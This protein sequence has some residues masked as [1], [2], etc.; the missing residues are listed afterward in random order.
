MS[1]VEKLGTF[2]DKLFDNTYP[3]HGSDGK[4]ANWLSKPF[5]KDYQ[6]HQ[7]STTLYGGPLGGFI[8]DYGYQ[9]DKTGS[10][11]SALKYTGSQM[12][13]SAGVLAT[14]FAGI[15]GAGAYGAGGASGGSAGSSGAAGGSS[16]L[17][18]NGSLFGNEGMLGGQSIGS[19]GWES[20][21]PAS[22]FG[23]G[24]FLSTGNLGLGGVG[25]GMSG[26]GGIT[27]YLKKFMQN[28][29]G[30]QNQQ[31]V[32]QTQP[33]WSMFYAYKD[34]NPDEAQNK[35]VGPALRFY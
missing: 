14:I 18:S 19:L 5:G 27:D 32:Q 24:S 31:Q 11:D 8:S 15:A 26:G 3:E 16:F 22:L 28:G 12:K 10:D 30:Q 2:S 21:S 6:R 23:S 34:R 17:N 9:K 29:N 7:F 13:D 33:D 35:P 20:S 1:F 4:V 25:G